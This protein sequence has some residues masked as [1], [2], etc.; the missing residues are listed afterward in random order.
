[1]TQKCDNSTTSGMAHDF[2]TTSDEL[3]GRTYLYCRLCG[4]VRPL[5]EQASGPTHAK[6]VTITAG[7]N[8]A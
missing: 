1:M 4:E 8:A 7:S 2:S 5:I 3:A 6:T